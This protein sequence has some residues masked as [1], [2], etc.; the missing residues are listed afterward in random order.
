MMK[1]TRKGGLLVAPLAMLAFGVLLGG[2]SKD[3]VTEGAGTGVIIQTS[4][5]LLN[6]KVGD[7][8][9]VTGQ[10]L[11]ARMTALVATITVTSSNPGA[12]AIDS[13][14]FYS[15]LSETV[16]YLRAAGTKKDSSNVTWTS[17]GFTA[18]T[19]VVVTF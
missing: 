11:D 3:P 17:G 12:V 19:K 9:Q 7:K 8:F 15:P 1:M 6:Q 13:T 4:R 5:A 2:C 14:S 16:A 18:T 10:V